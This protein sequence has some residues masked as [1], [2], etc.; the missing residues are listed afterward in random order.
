MPGVTHWVPA[1]PTGFLFIIGPSL[2]PPQASAQN[3]LPRTPLTTHPHALTPCQ[4]A[5]CSKVTAT[6]GHC[7]GYADLNCTLP[8]SWPHGLITNSMC[9]FNISQKHSRRSPFPP[10][11]LVG[12]RKTCSIPHLW[13]TAHSRRLVSIELMNFSDPRLI[14]PFPSLLECSRGKM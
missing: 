6:K 13:N 10:H 1:T 3:L 12:S 2:P 11:Q 8:S 9:L 14:P 7:P 4:K 5:L